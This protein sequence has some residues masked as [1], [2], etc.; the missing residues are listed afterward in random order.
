MLDKRS[1]TDLSSPPIHFLFGNHC[2]LFL[3]RWDILYESCVFILPFFCLLF[4]VS[5]L[6]GASSKPRSNICFN[7]TDPT[8]RWG[9]RACSQ[10]YSRGSVDGGVKRKLCEADWYAR[11]WLLQ[12][13]V[14]M[15][16]N[17]VDREKKYRSLLLNGAN[18]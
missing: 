4:W 11:L 5:I 10:M 8:G 7:P 16:L 14:L 1:L 3:M 12:A 2:P 13:P 17:I 9:L 18:V 15:D 6:S